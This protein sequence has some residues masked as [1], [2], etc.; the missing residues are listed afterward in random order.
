MIAPAWLDWRAHRGLTLQ[1]GPACNTVL[2]LVPSIQLKQQVMEQ[3]QVLFSWSPSSVDS[4]KT[5]CLAPR[6]GPGRS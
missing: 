6:D 4:S 2:V 5:T 3:M 1:K